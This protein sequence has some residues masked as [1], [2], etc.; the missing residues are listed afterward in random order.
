MKSPRFFNRWNST[1]LSRFR[2]NNRI[3]KLKSRF[4][5]VFSTESPTLVMINHNMDLVIPL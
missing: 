5:V 3:S 1:Q 2:V 4:Q